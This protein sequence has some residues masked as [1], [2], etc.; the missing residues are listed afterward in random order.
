MNSTVGAAISV[1]L[2]CPHGF[3][4]Q[5]GTLACL[6]QQTIRDRIEVILV[7]PSLDGLGVEA[8]CLEPFAGFKVVEVGMIRCI[9]EAYAAGVRAASAGLVAAGED[10]SYPKADWA[11]TLVRAHQQPWA[12]VGPLIV[13]RN[14]RN[15]VGWADYFLTY[16]PWS[17]SRKAGEME[18]LPGHNSSYKRAVLLEYGDRLGGMMQNESLLHWDLRRRGYRLLFEPAAQ[19]FHMCIG[20]LRSW[21]PTVASGGRA[22]ASYR[23]KIEGWSW[24]RRIAFVM[25]S[26]LVPV[27]RLRRALRQVRDC[28]DGPA[29]RQ[30]APLLAFAMLLDAAGQAVGCA[31]G[32]GSSPATLIRYEFH[33]EED[34]GPQKT[35]MMVTASN[36]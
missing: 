13:N 36:G 8:A 32:P 30:V 35:E 11:E 18:H 4:A 27:I 23:Q 10:H 34:M 5:R 20:R 2:I 21:I 16:G 6:R 12:A 14:R 28:Q 26:P 1:V 3:A 33:R 9:G 24:L 7:A 25:A 31:F 29:V 15:M 22:F 19:T 17:D